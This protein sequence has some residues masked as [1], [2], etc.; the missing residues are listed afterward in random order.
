MNLSESQTKINLMRSFAGESQARNRYTLAAGVAA[1]KKLH[2]VEAVFKF[3]A[4][5]ELAHAKIFYDFLKELTGENIKIDGTYPVDVYDDVLK[6]LRSAEH[7]ENEEFDPVYPDFASI[8]NKEGFTN[9]GAKFKAIAEIEKTHA[10]RFKQFAD[11]MEQEK[12]FVSDVEEE[13]M[14]LNCGHT[15]KSSEAPKVCPVCNHPQGYFIRVSLAPYTAKQG[16]SN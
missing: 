7:N 11:L 10:Q 16:G 4:E 3:T 1:N 8:A 12:L 2:V 15:V 6:L 14:C 9:I 13:W 5:Q